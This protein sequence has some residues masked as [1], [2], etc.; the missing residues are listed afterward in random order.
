MIDKASPSKGPLAQ[1]TLRHNNIAASTV[2]E[3]KP[4]APSSID[5]KKSFVPASSSGAR[6]SNETPLPPS[7]QASDK[8]RASIND[9][10]PSQP[11]EDSDGNKVEEKTIGDKIAQ[12]RTTGKSPSNQKR[13][14]T[15]L[16]VLCSPNKKHPKTTP[17]LDEA[18]KRSD[19]EST[20]GE[21]TA[22]PDDGNPTT[23]AK[24]DPR[25]PTIPQSVF[26]N[27]EHRLQQFLRRYTHA[28]RTITIWEEKKHY[29]MK[30]CSQF[31]ASLENPSSKEFFL[32]IPLK[33]R[34]L[35]LLWRWCMVGVHAKQDPRVSVAQ[36]QEFDV[37]FGQDKG[38]FNYLSCFREEIDV[39]LSQHVPKYRHAIHSRGTEVAH[40]LLFMHPGRFVK[41]LRINGS[42]VLFPLSYEECLK[43]MKHLISDWDKTKPKESAAAKSPPPNESAHVLTPETTQPKPPVDKAPKAANGEPEKELVPTT[44]PP[45]KADPSILMRFHNLRK[46]DL[47]IAQAAA[48]ASSLL[49]Y[50][51]DQRRCRTNV[52]L[53]PTAFQS[54]I[55]VLDEHHQNESFTALALS[56]FVVAKSV[57]GSGAFMSAMED[58]DVS[59]IKSV[60][61]AMKF[62][63][64]ASVDILILACSILAS[65]GSASDFCAQRIQEAGGLQIIHKLYHQ[66]ASLDVQQQAQRAWAAITGRVLTRQ[67][68]NK[69]T[70]EQ[71]PAEV[72]IID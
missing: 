13:A 17:N 40:K 22:K 49:I 6:V 72:I 7:K 20:Q 67:M 63:F 70:K 47:S 39:F 46:A 2:Q 35:W 64:T 15:S 65:A 59:A 41:G 62:F 5:R 53:P 56:L 1:A 37:I 52:D 3:D 25:I 26:S 34:E 9:E 29:A 66:H 32:R 33:D 31:E 27:F 71:K 10:N 50:L 61:F 58:I 54:I 4:P 68:V 36:I 44:I 19:K 28:F 23:L 48:M 55:H 43:T 11:N 8:K 12:K 42:T 14:P 38:T 60:V 16:N 24:N 45:R 51:Q 21:N 18:L 30:L 57:D 69:S